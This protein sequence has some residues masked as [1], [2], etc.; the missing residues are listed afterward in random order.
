MINIAVLD[1]EA[2]LVEEYANYINSWIERNEV[3]GNLVLA[4]TSA[5]E[6]LSI[7]SD[8]LVNVFIIDINL[9]KNTN[10][11]NVA[12]QIRKLN[13]AC[14]IIFLTGCLE[15]IQQAF[16][17]HAYQFIAKPGLDI[18]KRTLIALSK[19]A[20]MHRNKCIDIK[21]G[22]QVFFVPVS[23]ITHIEHLK[24]KTVVHTTDSEYPSYEG[25]EGLLKRINDRRFKRCHRSIFINIS[26]L[27]C[28]DIKNKNL[29]LK[30]GVCCNIGPKYYNT[31]IM[32]K[33][34]RNF[35][36]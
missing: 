12:R 6:F 13:D 26:Y 28:L 18:L 15:Y 11:I 30:N 33:N 10:G 19:E 8:R 7:V 9:R 21:C 34:W 5:D 35:L 24:N 16:D 4:T 29:I 14:E 32:N 2:Y 20:M 25:L 23:E 3:D 17:V 22:S 36:C 1:D 27:H 31:Y